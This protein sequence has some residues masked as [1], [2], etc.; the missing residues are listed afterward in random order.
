MIWHQP[1]GSILWPSNPGS[2]VT[3]DNE[4]IRCVDGQEPQIN[5]LWCLSLYNINQEVHPTARVEVVAGTVGEFTTNYLAENRRRIPII[6]KLSINGSVQFLGIPD[7][8]WG[9]GL[10]FLTNLQAPTDPTGWGNGGV[11]IITGE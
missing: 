10:S 5:E 1:M 11:P 4:F 2:R 9:F 7:F 6:G 3:E 8:V